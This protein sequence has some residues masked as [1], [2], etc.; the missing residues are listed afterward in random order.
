MKAQKFTLFDNNSTKLFKEM[1]PMTINMIELNE[2]EKNALWFKHVGI[3]LK[4]FSTSFSYTK[5]GCIDDPSGLTSALGSGNVAVTF[6]HNSLSL[7]LCG[8]N[9]KQYRLRFHVSRLNSPL[10]QTVY[11]SPYLFRRQTVCGFEMSAE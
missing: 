2:N 3:I 9:I 8:K 10:Q 6:E 11:L 1:L 4:T 7:C 5:L